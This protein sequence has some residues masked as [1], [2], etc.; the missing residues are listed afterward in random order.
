MATARVGLF[1]SA[2]FLALSF[3]GC[4]HKQVQSELVVDENFS[5]LD[6]T[7][8]QA[9][10]HTFGCNEAQFIPTNVKIDGG[11]LAISL[12]PTPN[13][14]RKYSGGELKF[15]GQDPAK[16]DDVFSYGRYEVRMK[17]AKIR[18]AVSSFFLYRINPWQEIDIE[19]IEGEQRKV[20]TNVFYNPG[21]A[22]SFNNEMIMDPEIIDVDFDTSEGFHTYAF[23]WSEKEI[24]WY[25]DGKL[26]RT[27]KAPQSIP[28]LPMSLRMN[29]WITCD[30][31]SDWAGKFEPSDLPGT[32]HYEQIRIWNPKP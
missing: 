15:K 28:D 27:R 11:K 7:K 18:G 26:I 3:V 25:A 5:K 23:E 31:A 22:G 29:H 30:A 20:L 1:A 9:L 4:A 21:P 6:P 12:T 8:W 16:G 24:R 14:D 17:P 13:G 32:V 19:M 10:A 2:M